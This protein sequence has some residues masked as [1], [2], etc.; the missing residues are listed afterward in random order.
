MKALSVKQPWAF[1]IGGG[2]KTIELRSWSTDYRGQILICS[3]KSEKDAWAV[4]DGRYHQLPAGV[5]MCVA[6]LVDVRQIE[7][8]ADNQ[9][10]AFVDSIESGV[11]GW[12]LENIRHCC[13]KPVNGKLRLFDIDENEIEFVGENYDFFADAV[14]F[15]T[16]KQPTEKSIVLNYD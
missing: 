4:V 16:G 12:F 13:L 7:D 5:M 14:Q 9:D 11:Y 1:L 8:T 10:A 6:D 3:S 2:E 15:A